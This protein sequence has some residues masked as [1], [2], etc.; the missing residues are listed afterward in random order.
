MIIRPATLTDAPAMTA[1]LNAVI[2]IVTEDYVTG[3]DV[4]ASV[5]AEEDGRLL[6]WQS[7]GL[8]QDEAHIGTFVQPGL[9]AKGAGRAMFGLTCQM[10]RQKGVKAIIASIR[11][12]NVPGLAYYGRIGFRDIGHEPDFS[13]NDGTVVGRVH[14]RF[15]L[16]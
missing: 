4:L 8:W 7:V 15:D 1:L 13:L 11:A 10:L 14:R 3:P 16:V 6:G 2:A 9:Q 12:D 5:V